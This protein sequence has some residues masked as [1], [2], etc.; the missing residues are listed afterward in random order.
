MNRD[1]QQ[2]KTRLPTQ[3]KTTTKKSKKKVLPKEGNKL[4]YEIKKCVICGKRKMEKYDLKQ[5]DRYVTINKCKYCKF[6]NSSEVVAYSSDGGDAY[7]V[8]YFNPKRLLE[9]KS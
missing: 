1:G 2:T 6:I 8:N 7:S 4:N 9:N 5:D 3:Y